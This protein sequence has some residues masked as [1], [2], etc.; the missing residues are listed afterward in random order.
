[1]QNKD[2]RKSSLYLAVYSFFTSLDRH[3]KMNDHWKN[4]LYIYL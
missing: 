3:E 4:Y 1:M 2:D